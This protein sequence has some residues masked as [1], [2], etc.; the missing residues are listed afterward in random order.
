MFRRP[1]WIL[2]YLPVL[3]F[4]ACKH[5]EKNAFYVSGTFKNADKLISTYLPGTGKDS[6]SQEVLTK[7]YLQEVPY[8]KDQQPLNLDSLTLK[9]S[10]GH[11]DLKATGKSQGI[12]ELIFGDNLM[13]IPL[14]N[15][16]ADITVNIDLGKKDDFY[17]VSGSEA[18]KQL[19]ELIGTLGKKN[20]LIE[21]SFNDLDSL[22]RVSA[23]D[24]LISAVTREKDKELDDLNH[25]LQHFI[26]SSS[27]PTL[28]LLALGWSSRSFSKSDFESSLLELYRK[29]PDN[30]A[31]L[32]MKK[33]YE[34]QKAQQAEMEKK[35]EDNTWTG[36]QAPDFTLPDANGKDISLSSFKGK[37]VLVDFWASWCAPCRQENPNVVKAYNEFKAKNFT[38]LGVSLDKEKEAWL[39]AIQDDHLTW[40]H[41]S[42]LKF[43]NSKAVDVFKFDGIPFNVL[44]DPQGRILAQQLRGDDLENKLREVLK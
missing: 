39:K 13:A 33:S 22:K 42:D 35:Q 28:A 38:I 27:N 29:Y 1:C 16:A 14:I 10:S 41:V 19:Q 20:F 7:V 8:G 3:F 12:Y 21:K 6:G 4:C 2:A 26:S 11:Y 15:D 25:Y 24:T 23:P 43:W 34:A 44:I 18:S 31:I 32:N 37:Y 40:T 9:G 36:K 5:L 17:E 30:V